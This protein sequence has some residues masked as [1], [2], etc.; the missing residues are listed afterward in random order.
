MVSDRIGIGRIAPPPVGR[1]GAD[2]DVNLPGPA[3]PLFDAF[4]TPDGVGISSRKIR[5]GSGR[6][7]GEQTP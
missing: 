6:E 4:L 1:S 7:I 2:R 5:D 3:D